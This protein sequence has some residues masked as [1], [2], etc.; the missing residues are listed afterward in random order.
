M[1]PF[2]HGF[3]RGTPEQ[4]KVWRAWIHIKD[5]CLNPN[6][7]GYHRYGGRGITIAKEWVNDFQAFFAYVGYAPTPKHTIERINNDGGYEPGNVK[8]ATNEE[9]QANKTQGVHPRYKSEKYIAVVQAF[10]QQGMSTR[11]IAKHTGLAKSLVHRIVS[12]GYDG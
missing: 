5:R 8:W 7:I 9:Q 1:P 11:T 6:T 2:K 12:G 3:G 10:H 4:K